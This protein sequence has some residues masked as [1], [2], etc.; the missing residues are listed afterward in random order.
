MWCVI[1]F[2]KWE[3]QKKKWMWTVESFT[4]YTGSEKF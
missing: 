3:G 2:S 4:N 1:K